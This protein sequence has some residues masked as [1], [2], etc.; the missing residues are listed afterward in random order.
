MLSLNKQVGFRMIKPILFITLG[1]GV[2]AVNVQG[3]EAD[4]ITASLTE[5]RFANDRS[6]Y[7][8]GMPTQV[9]T[10]RRSEPITIPGLYNVTAAIPDEY[11]VAS[12]IIENGTTVGLNLVNDSNPQD[13]KPFSIYNGGNKLPLFQLGEK[14]YSYIR[15]VKDFY[16]DRNYVWAGNLNIIGEPA[17]IGVASHSDGWIEND[18]VDA[19]IDANGKMSKIYRFHKDYNFQNLIFSRQSGKITPN[20][21]LWRYK[22]ISAHNVEISI[23][24]A[25]IDTTRQA[26]LVYGFYDQESAASESRQVKIM[27]NNSSKV[28]NC[29]YKG[30]GE[31][32]FTANFDS[33]ILVNVSEK[34]NISIININGFSNYLDFVEI[35][36][37]VLEEGANNDE[38]YSLNTESTDKVPNDNYYDS[39]S[40]SFRLP[41][42][43]LVKVDEAYDGPIRINS[44][45]VAIGLSEQAGQ[46][47]LLLFNKYSNME[48]ESTASDKLIYFASAPVRSG[49]R[50]LNF[51]QEKELK[52][53][54]TSKNDYLAIIPED[55]NYFLK[56]RDQ[57]FPDEDDKSAFVMAP[58]Q[59]KSFNSNLYQTWMTTSKNGKT[60]SDIHRD[61]GLKPLY[62]KL[63]DVIDTYGCGLYSPEGIV[64]LLGESQTVEYVCLVSGT[65]CDMQKQDHNFK[66]YNDGTHR[67]SYYVQTPGVPTGFFY[68]RKAGITTTDDIYCDGYQQSKMVGR[69]L[70][71]TDSDLTAWLKR[72]I[73]YEPSDTVSFWAGEN[74][75]TNF[76]SHQLKKQP[77]KVY[78]HLKPSLK[79]VLQI[80][81]I[82]EVSLRSIISCLKFKC[83]K[84]ITDSGRT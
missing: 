45:G 66:T 10:A 75:G 11:S 28:I 32:L 3:Q 30:T 73:S 58:W 55:I 68:S 33:S 54:D 78:V 40:K 52:L 62:L 57:R 84:A 82:D 43:L 56:L 77:G 4:S 34:V 20:G 46:E 15:T 41:K 51:D 5:I 38:G 59:E 53:I 19:V 31:K 76:T 8:K 21:P 35:Y 71:Y 13:T 26:K 44:T 47:K 37:P 70:A 69:V 25:K 6:F 48:V 60:I 2:V 49:S 22:R 80:Y 17:N 23:A 1:L 64:K 63:E 7:C 36:V 29:G 83:L 72:R 81:S 74:R 14:W 65:T 61:A 42:R 27:V 67:Q 50:S 16:N 24:G 79:E 39:S 12:Q 9:G 18:G